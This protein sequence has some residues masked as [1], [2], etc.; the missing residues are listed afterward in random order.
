L[1]SGVAES[2]VKEAEAPTRKIIQ[3]E[4]TKVAD[5]MINGLA[6]LSASALAAIGTWYLVDPK[7]K[8]MKFAG[9]GSAAALSG[10]GAII[11]AASLREPSGPQKAPGTTSESVKSVSDQAAASMVAAAEPKIRAIVNEERERV[12]GSVQSGLPLAAGG[13]LA[14]VITAMMVDDSKAWMK[15]SGY[16][17]SVLLAAAGAWIAL[18]RVKK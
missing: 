16:S 1:T 7:S 3:E 11:T 5:A 13:A 12:A 18:D 17:A 2:I 6:W 14:A 9:Y 15:V 8:A 4:R 10:A